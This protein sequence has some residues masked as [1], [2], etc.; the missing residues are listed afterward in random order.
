VAVHATQPGV[1]LRSLRILVTALTVAGLPL[2][3][4]LFVKAA[5]VVSYS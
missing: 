5:S 1:A 4:P 3:A 2:P